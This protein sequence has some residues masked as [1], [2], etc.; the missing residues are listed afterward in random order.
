M[1]LLILFFLPQEPQEKA[2]KAEV[3]DAS[4]E[5]HE[6]FRDDGYIELVL[7]I[8]GFLC[9]GQQRN[10]QVTLACFSDR[11]KSCLSSQWAHSNEK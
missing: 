9:D 10:L 6:T 8:L 1:I 11:I 5:K 2:E 3:K 4:A 7:R